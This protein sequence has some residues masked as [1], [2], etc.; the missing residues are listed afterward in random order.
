MKANLLGLLAGIGICALAVQP[1]TA[2]TFVTPTGSQTGTGQPLSASAQ[3]TTSAGSVSFVLTNLLTAAQI[4]DAAQTISDVSFTL[5]NAPGTLGT[6]TGAAQLANIGAGGTVTNVAGTPDR[7]T[8]APPPIISG[9]TIN[10]ST[11]LQGQ[12][13]ELI[14]PSGGPFTNANASITGGQF[15]PFIVGPLT[16]TLALS[17]V[18]AATQVIAATFSFG[19]G[20]ETIIAVPGPLAGAGLPGL[21]AACVGLI[22]M[23]RRRRQAAIA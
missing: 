13:A 18:T 22:A 6:V 14:L 15:N 4:N 20:P 12:P 2:V 16:I 10:F 3:I 8:T 11:L 9:N 5:S 23:A 1:A 7:W 17:G 21:I 19:T